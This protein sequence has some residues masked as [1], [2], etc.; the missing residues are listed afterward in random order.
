ME[1]KRKHALLSASGAEKWFNCTPSARLE[2]QFPESQS[3]YADEGTVAHELAEI[4]NKFSLEIID[5]E[6]AA[7]RMLQIK[8]KDEYLTAEMTSYIN[9]F[10]NFVQA[11][12]REAKTAD[13]Y[14][15]V[16]FE[17]R[18]DFSRYVPDGFG[19]GDVVIVAGNGL[20]I[21][22]L[23]YGKGVPIYAEDNKQMMLYA[24]GAY[25]AFGW[26]Y[27][28]KKIKMTIYQPRL[29]NISTF[30]MS[31]L[32]LTIWA[33]EY[34]SNRAQLAYD[35]A[36]EYCPGEHCRFCRAKAVCRARAEENLRL[37]NYEFKH[38]DLLSNDEVADIL[39]IADRLTAWVSDISHYALEE[40]VSGKRFKGFK[41]VE[42]RS[43]R[44]YSDTEKV[45]ELLANNGYSKDLI[46]K[47][48]IISI[49][50]M[51]KLLTKTTFNTLLKDYIIK[52]P[53]KPTLV[54]ENDKREEWS[55]AKNDFQN[56]NINEL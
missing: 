51:E 11:E 44:V 54:L 16:Y 24:L 25:E 26:L 15:E 14:A 33:E 8:N 2:E 32:G 56:I 30:E 6:E 10:S 18:L 49:T 20:H 45:I 7:R 36:G 5:S 46:T 38:P 27:D 42:G 47:S 52:P 19:T 28:I 23:K 53:G 12:F 55:C 35:G 29:D 37:Q 40:A 39:L 34:L 9:E 13:K 31:R 17:Q 43:N 22:D 1:V 41:L 4:M 3:S 50:D 21:I 48:A